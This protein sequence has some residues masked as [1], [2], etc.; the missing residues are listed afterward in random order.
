M[1]FSGS[2]A[3]RQRSASTST[4]VTSGLR[5]RARVLR[6]SRMND[7]GIAGNVSRG[8]AP[9]R[10]GCSRDVHVVRSSQGP[11][12]GTGLLA[13]ADASSDEC[14][15]ES[16]EDSISQASASIL[17]YVRV[18]GVGRGGVSKCLIEVVLPELFGSMRGNVMAREGDQM[19]AYD[20]CKELIT[21]LK[22]RSELQQGGTKI[23]VRA[24][25]VES[26]PARYAC[27]GAEL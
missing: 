8:G 9:H 22:R 27:T 10:H 16:L 11:V 21:E 1:A 5:G 6:H 19:R 2:R 13:D 14:L 7:K 12:E 25:S 3:C 24:T 4:S 26:T 23:M 20:L 17:E 15:P 18:E